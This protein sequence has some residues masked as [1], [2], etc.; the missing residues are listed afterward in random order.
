MGMTEEQMQRLTAEKQAGRLECDE[1]GR[2]IGPGEPTASEG[3]PDGTFK[4]F[5]EDCLHR[6]SER[7]GDRYEL[8]DT[9]T[10]E[11]EGIDL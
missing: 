5:C 1:C 8:L 7:P 4:V 11:S 10:G 9:E 2:S 6:I 3:W